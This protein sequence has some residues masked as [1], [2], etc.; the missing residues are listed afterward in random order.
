MQI[1][2][3]K[4]TRAMIEDVLDSYTKHGLTFR[5]Y[6]A[7]SDRLVFNWPFPGWSKG[8]SGIT[9][10]MLHLE[11]RRK[12]LQFDVRNFIL[13]YHNCTAGVRIKRDAS[14]PKTTIKIKA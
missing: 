11:N 1:G 12:A 3:N 2:N 6:D 5:T 9:R 13:L 7:A 10:R 8:L 4:A 14:W